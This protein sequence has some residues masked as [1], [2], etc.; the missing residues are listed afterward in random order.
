MVPSY[1]ERLSDNIDA[2]ILVNTN[3]QEQSAKH[4]PLVE[5][6]I[7]KQSELLKENIYTNS[8]HDA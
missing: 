8:H 5:E 6:A 4:L 1:E 7:N 3:T 2:N